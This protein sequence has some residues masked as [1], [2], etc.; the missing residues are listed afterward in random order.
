MYVLKRGVLAVFDDQF[1]EDPQ[2]QKRLGKGN[3]FGEMAILRPTGQLGRLLSRRSHSLR[4]MGY[5]EVYL[6]TQEDALAV[7]VDY[8]EQRRSLIQKG[9]K[10]HLK[11][12]IF[13]QFLQPLKF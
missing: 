8:P 1:I 5:S 4:S 9:T 10:E 11:F 12:C 6:L 7:F 3:A 13:V 2:Q